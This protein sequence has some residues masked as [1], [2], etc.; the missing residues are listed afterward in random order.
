MS[1]FSSPRPAAQDDTP[2]KYTPSGPLIP[3]GDA[4]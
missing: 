2:Y 4:D 1:W 3:L